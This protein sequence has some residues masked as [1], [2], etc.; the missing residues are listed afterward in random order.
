MNVEDFN[1]DLPE[2]LIAQTPLKNRSESRLLVLDKNTGKIEHKVF[3]DI[4][5]YFHKGDT[6]VLN[7]TKVLP[8]RL[9]GEK[10]TTTLSQKDFVKLV[11]EEVEQRKLFKK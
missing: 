11:T 4:K 2:E 6:L 8:A 1:Y 3:K 9:F 7:N 5:N 10:E